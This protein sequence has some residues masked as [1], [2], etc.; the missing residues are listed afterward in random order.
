VGALALD[1]APRQYVRVQAGWYRLSASGFQH[2]GV[3]DP[4]VGRTTVVWGPA[5]T[6]PR[7]D[8]GPATVSGSLGQADVVEN[9]GTW[10]Q[11][12]D[13]HLWFLNSN[14]VRVTMQACPPAT[15]S[16]TQA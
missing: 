10:I 9:E 16:V 13:A 15:I 3:L 8:P 1:S 14:G 12:P 6:P 2:G 11:L 7:Y 5:T 4:K